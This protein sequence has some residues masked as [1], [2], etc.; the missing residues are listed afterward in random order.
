MTGR[1][2]VAD[3]GLASDIQLTWWVSEVAE[4]TKPDQSC[5]ATARMRNG[6]G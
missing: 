1:I 2:L 6:T 5:G 3:R 4:L